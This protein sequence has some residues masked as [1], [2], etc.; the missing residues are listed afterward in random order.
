MPEIDTLQMDADDTSLNK[1][2]VANRAIVE[3]VISFF[4]VEIGGAHML[5]GM[6]PEQFDVARRL[7]AASAARLGA[8]NMPI[9]RNRFNVRPL[10]T[11]ARA[12]ATA[13]SAHLVKSVLESFDDI[14]AEIWSSLSLYCKGKI[15]AAN[16]QVIEALR[17]FFA[18]RDPAAHLLFGM[19]SASFALATR[20]Q[21]VDWQR[22]RDLEQPIWAVRFDLNE[23][24][25]NGDDDPAQPLAR[26]S[27]V[28]ALL[29]GFKDVDIPR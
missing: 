22:L 29:R 18:P 4:N 17:S 2:R 24:P 10:G 15:R 19:T 3:A 20:L 8:L 7:S 27:V 25:F 23:L 21:F 5:F 16:D 28:A 14:P 9:W 12:G 13:D 11:F 1:I 6:S 26:D